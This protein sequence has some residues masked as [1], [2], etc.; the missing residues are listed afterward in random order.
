MQESN[1]RP[2][3]AANSADDVADTASSSSNESASFVYEGEVQQADAEPAAAAGAEPDAETDEEVDETKLNQD[4]MHQCRR[5]FQEFENGAGFLLTHELGSALR[6]LGQVPSEREVQL[7]TDRLEQPELYD[8]G[9][10]KLTFQ[11]FYQAA[12]EFKASKAE[13]KKSVMDAFSV[14]DKDDNGSIE[15]NRLTS[16]LASLGEPLSP[17]D[18]KELLKEL[19]VDK[20]GRVDY[21]KFVDDAVNCDIRGATGKSTAKGKGSK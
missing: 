6:A 21:A 9:S 3:S 16:I 8:R 14:L 4:L 17:S 12:Q 18:I 1:S 15:V 2:L 20:N 19:P 10:T 11:D 7:A 13:V 5:V